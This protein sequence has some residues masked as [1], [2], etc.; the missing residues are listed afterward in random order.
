MLKQDAEVKESSFLVFLH[1]E[2][3]SDLVRRRHFNFGHGI[4][5][6]GDICEVQP[7]AA[8]S[9]TLNKLTNSLVLDLFKQLG[10]RACE[11]A[12]VI[13]TATGMAITL[14]LLALRKKRPEGAKYVLWNR[15]DQKSCFKSILCAGKLHI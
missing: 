14:C 5:R 13:P 4:G 2:V 1:L 15:I 12:F 11:A 9:S 8:G 3:F 10:L 7:K 6:S